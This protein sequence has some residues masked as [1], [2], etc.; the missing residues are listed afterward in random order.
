MRNFATLGWNF[1]LLTN[2]GSKGRSV[3]VLA[4]R[5]NAP[6]FFMDDIAQHHE[7]VAEQAPNVFRIHFVGDERL[8]P[9]MPTS[10]HAHFRAGTWPEAHAF[11]RARL[12]KD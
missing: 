1:P 4:K 11:I 8:K 3:R 5:A 9:L 7:S 6:T 12:R 10:P 2:S